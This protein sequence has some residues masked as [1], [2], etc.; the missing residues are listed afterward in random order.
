MV[1]QEGGPNATFLAA[2]AK[3]I[4]DSEA[5]TRDFLAALDNTLRIVVRLE[6]AQGIDHAADVYQIRRT[7]GYYIVGGYD[8]SE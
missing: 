6:A 3:T 7:L 1:N 8:F 2:L 5:D 4:C